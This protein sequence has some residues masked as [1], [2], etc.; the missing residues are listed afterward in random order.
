MPD[1]K[2]SNKNFNVQTGGKLASPST[3][4]MVICGDTP[5]YMKLYLKD[6]MYLHNMPKQYANLIICLLRRISYAGD[7]DGMC[8]TLVSRTKKAICNEMG[9]QRTSTLDN[10][11]HKLIEGKILSR[12]DRGIFKFNS[13]LFGKDTWHDIAKVQLE[14]VYDDINGRTFSAH[15]D[16]R[17]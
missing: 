9:W 17:K 4:D 16:C 8:V 7:S 1:T 6:V 3:N 2:Q 5:K 10:A 11:L 12:V 15:V 13:M 14:I